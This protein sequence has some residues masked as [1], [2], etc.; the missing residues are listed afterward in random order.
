MTD[1]CTTCG[2]E[3]DP[4]CKT[5]GCSDKP[6]YYPDRD[7]VNRRRALE[8]VLLAYQ[9]VDFDCDE[10]HPTIEA[11]RVANAALNQPAPEAVDVESL[12]KTTQEDCDYVHGWS[13][14]LDYLQ[15]RGL[16]AQGWIPP[17]KYKMEDGDHVITNG[18]YTL[19]HTSKLCLLQRF[20]DH[21]NQ[22]L[23]ETQKQEEG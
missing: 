19:R 9:G 13:A 7:A 4:A 20:L 10:N 14:C 2:R 11:E 6:L 12:R 1:K 17:F 21:V 8:G 5:V 23:A 22:H 16:I 15:E 18:R 3:N